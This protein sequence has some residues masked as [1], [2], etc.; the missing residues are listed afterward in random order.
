MADRRQRRLMQEAL[1]EQLSPEAQQ[2]LHER[3]EV[4]AEG[5]AEYNRLRRVDRLLRTAPFERAPARLAMSIMA[6]MVEDLQ[7]HL[8][9]I[10]GLALA[11]ALALVTLV[12]FPI[13][14][15]ISWL[16]IAVLTSA[17][18]LTLA[19]LQFANVLAGVRGLL[20]V[21]VEQSQLLLDSYPQLP[22]ALL[23]FIP[24]TGLWV[25]LLRHISRRSRMPS[26]TGT[27]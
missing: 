24:L 21:M 11:L 25:W 4:D 14:L 13:L 6:K 27:V 7:P 18:S 1:D 17:A 9:R 10:S 2:E 8:S 19:A 3:L 20:E 16:L 15:A 26:G 5:A 22:L 23:A 12:L